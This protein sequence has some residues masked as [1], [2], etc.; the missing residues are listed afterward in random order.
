MRKQIFN[1]LD[2]KMK[3]ELSRREGLK[4]QL[5]RKEEFKAEIDAFIA[6]SRVAYIELIELA[7]DYYG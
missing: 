5:A 6:K 2:L 4:S 7:E 3:E 1:E